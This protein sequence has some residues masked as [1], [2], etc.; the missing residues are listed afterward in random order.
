MG[1]RRL[2]VSQREG[3][4]NYAKGLGHRQHYVT[5]DRSQF[6]GSQ[7]RLVYLMNLMMVE[8]A[9]LLKMFLAVMQQLQKVLP[10]KRNV[11][12][13]C[14][15]KCSTVS[16]DSS[17]LGHFLVRDLLMAQRCLLSPQR[18]VI[19][20]RMVMIA[21]TQSTTVQLRIV[22]DLM[23]SRDERLSVQIIRCLLVS[24]SSELQASRIAVSSA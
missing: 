10:L 13:N 1:E 18:P 11:A 22:F 15:K 6:S 16:S 8:R 14:P 19:M 2:D 7:K 21:A 5:P 9:C 3:S 12:G 20:W 24:S 23:A 17:Q 4:T